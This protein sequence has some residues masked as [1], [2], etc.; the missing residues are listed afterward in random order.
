MAGVLIY[1]AAYS[2][3]L[4][5]V[6]RYPQACVAALVSVAHAISSH[7]IPITGQLISITSHTAGW[8]KVY[9]PSPLG[10]TLK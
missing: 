5:A 1:N 9:R 2:Q 8:T 10:V 3:N 6:V 4:A 7:E